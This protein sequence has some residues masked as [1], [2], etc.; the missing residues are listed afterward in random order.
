MRTQIPF[1]AQILWFLSSVLFY[2]NVI[3][4]GDRAGLD[5]WGQ[6]VG[7]I[8]AQ[9]NDHSDY[10]DFVVQGASPIMSARRRRCGSWSLNLAASLQQV[11][12][13]S[14]ELCRSQNRYWG[15]YSCFALY[16]PR[17]PIED[18]VCDFRGSSL[19]RLFFGSRQ[20]V[21]Y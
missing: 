10:S 8:W 1:Q 7:Q 21:L 6:F 11:R 9:T 19:R 20:S 3:E 5:S 17:R 14:S 12:S 18:D 13:T 16:R 15:I 2:L 4:I